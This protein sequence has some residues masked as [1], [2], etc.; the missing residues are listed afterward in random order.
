MT[1]L[2]LLMAMGGAA[3]LVVAKRASLRRKTTEDWVIAIG[4]LLLVAAFVFLIGPFT[5]R[6]YPNP[7]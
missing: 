2:I 4:I 1:F 7:K 6:E 5:A 3:C